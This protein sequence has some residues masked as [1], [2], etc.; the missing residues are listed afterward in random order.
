MPALEFLAFLAHINSCLGTALT[1]PKGSE[2]LFSLSFPDGAT[3]R[4]RY[5]G[6]LGHNTPFA[7]PRG[8]GLLIQLMPPLSDEDTAAY[9]AASE[10]A[11]HAFH[12][13]LA[14]LALSTVYGKNNEAREVKRRARNAEFA[15]A[16]DSL[17]R[18]L[19]NHPESVAPPDVNV[20][21]VSLDIEWIEWNPSWVSEIGIVILDLQDVV[22]VPLK[23][24]LPADHSQWVKSLSKAHHIR[25]SEYANMRNK[26]YVNGCPDKF[27]FG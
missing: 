10:D 17:K 1:I 13:T 14:S 2:R 8:L 20:V 7:T 24:P 25:V 15:K 26:K 6:R 12:Q 22:V 9:N 23:Y 11:R 18:W 27:D 16:L 19:G 5:L 21:L 3:P 4:P